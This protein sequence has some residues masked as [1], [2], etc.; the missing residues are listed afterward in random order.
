[1]VNPEQTQKVIYKKRKGRKKKHQ[2]AGTEPLRVGIRQNDGG[3]KNLR[4]REKMGGTK[5]QTRD[6]LASPR[7]PPKNQQR[8]QMGGGGGTTKHQPG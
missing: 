1:M 3:G 7:L 5:T 2:A 4:T 8:Q 6:K